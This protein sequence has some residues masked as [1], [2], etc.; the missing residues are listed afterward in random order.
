MTRARFAERAAE[1]LPGIVAGAPN[2]ARVRGGREGLLA[3]LAWEALLDRHHQRAAV[4]GLFAV[5][6]AGRPVIAL[7]DDGSPVD[8]VADFAAW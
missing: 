4:A 8:S 3:G 1:L 2:P 6:Q 7:R 5:W